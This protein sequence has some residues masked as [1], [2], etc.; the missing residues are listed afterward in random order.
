M[1]AIISKKTLSVVL[2]VAC[3]VV[4]NLA[5]SQDNRAANL[6]VTLEHRSP[7]T[8]VEKLKPL[9][10]PRGD[11]GRIA[12]KLII[13]TTAS[14][15]V[16]LENALAEFDVP[17]RRLVLSLDPSYGTGDDSD[18]QSMQALEFAQN[19]FV[20]TGNDAGMDETSDSLTNENIQIA[21][22]NITTEQASN[23]LTE[24]L[25]TLHIAAEVSGSS[26]M[27]SI[28]TSGIPTLSTSYQI[29]MPLGQWVV[30]EPMNQAIASDDATDASPDEISG[31]PAEELI[32]E[33]SIAIRVDVLP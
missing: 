1:N 31:A 30:L 20:L 5:Y 26:A 24:P 12:D 19:A 10:D 21:N 29:S 15:M 11:I 3:S 9:L 6:I 33:P 7:V 18:R 13:N 28:T 17:A 2:L 25:S 8:A 23:D 32:P 16:E 22:D 27:A 14:N 4:D